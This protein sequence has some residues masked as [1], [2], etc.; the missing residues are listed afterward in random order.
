MVGEEVLFE[1]VSIATAHVALVAEVPLDILEGGG[2]PAEHVIGGV[3]P[4]HLME[5]LVDAELCTKSLLADGTVMYEGPGVGLQMGLELCKVL[6]L[7]TA[8]GT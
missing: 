8:Y 2:L 3:D 7:G 1:V 6:V 5:V 4:V